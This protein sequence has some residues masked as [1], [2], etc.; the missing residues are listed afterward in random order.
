MKNKIF[1]VVLLAVVICGSLFASGNI[2]FFRE[3]SLMTKLFLGFFAA[4]I[5]LQII[6]GVL[7]FSSL[8][9]GVFGGKEKARDME[10][11]S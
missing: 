7:L 6:P 10:G 5:L 11:K 4:I 3:S 2:A 8:I 9:K 1:Q